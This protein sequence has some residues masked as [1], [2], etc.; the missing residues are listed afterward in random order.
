MVSRERRRE[1]GRASYHRRKQPPELSSHLCECG[2]GQHTYLAKQTSAEKGWVKGEPKR[3]V[4]GHNRRRYREPPAETRCHRCRM[5]KPA[6]EFYPDPAR[7]TGLASSC[8]ECRKTASKKRYAAD[9]EAS[10]AQNREWAAKH[11]E[12]MREYKASWSKA[13]PEQRAEVQNRRRVRLRSG[14]VEKIDP[15]EIYERDGG[16]CHICG[17]RVA[18]NKMSLDHL[19]PVARGGDHVALNVRLA[20]LSCNVKRGP[21]RTPAQLLLL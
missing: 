6:S 10:R 13:H 14:V 7:P 20:H 21:G 18:R 16:R 15:R 19:I 9:P 8:R 12:R 3:F 1:I 2:C 17:K 4:H 11:P 5:V